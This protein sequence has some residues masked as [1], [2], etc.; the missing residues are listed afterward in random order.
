VV[1]HVGD[2]W[3][4]EQAAEARLGALFSFDGDAR[5]GDGADLGVGRNADGDEVSLPRR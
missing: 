4:R 3:E 1:R 2:I 5:C